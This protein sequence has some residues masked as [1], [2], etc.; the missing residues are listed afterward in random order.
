MDLFDN[1]ND[2]FVN[3]I[4][5]Q[6]KDIQKSGNYGLLNHYDFLRIDRKINNDI[7][8]NK[9]V[10]TNDINIS[11]KGKKIQLIRLIYHTYIDN[12]NKNDILVNNCNENKYLCL[13]KNHIK[14]I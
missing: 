8:G 2:K 7:F 10:I 4:R 11:Y 1:T 3:L 9:C 13:C 5:N 12:I 14:K 6:R